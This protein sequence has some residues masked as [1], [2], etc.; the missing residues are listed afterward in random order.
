MIF[1]AL[2]MLTILLTEITIGGIIE[3]D[4][5]YKKL[6]RLKKEISDYEK[7]IF[8]EKMGSEEKIKELKYMY[9]DI[10]F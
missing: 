3:R 6:D 4:I 5:S 8:N 1:T 7:V 9:E 10:S 2:L